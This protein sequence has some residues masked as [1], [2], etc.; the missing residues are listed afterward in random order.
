MRNARKFILHSK[1]LILWEE[2][3]YV[4][5]ESPVPTSVLSQMLISEVILVSIASSEFV[6]I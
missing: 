3:K 5:V 4:G 2:G 1:C 6:K